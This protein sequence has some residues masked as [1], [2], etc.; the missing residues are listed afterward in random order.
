MGS[1]AAAT[2]AIGAAL[3]MSTPAAADPGGD[4]SERSPFAAGR[5][6]L[7]FAAGS[8]SSVVASDDDA[9]IYVGGGL[10]YFV[11][12]GLELGASGIKLFGAD[13]SVAML[14]PRVRYVFHQV[15]SS[16]KPY[17]GAFLTHWFLGDPFDDV[18]TLGARGGVITTSGRLLIGAGVAYEAV[19][20]ECDGDCD[21]IYPELTFA[22]AF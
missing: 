9:H 17:L 7:G 3:A 10:G 13:P 8:Q 18:D 20:T 12:P 5:I 15:P 14:S 2:I 22:V 11:L 16:F 21:L 4:G 6:T 19:I 1:A